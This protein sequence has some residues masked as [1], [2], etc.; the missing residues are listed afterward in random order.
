LY[1][2]WPL[3]SVVPVGVLTK[4]KRKQWSSLRSGSEFCA[5][6]QDRPPYHPAR[7]SCESAPMTEGAA[8]DEGEGEWG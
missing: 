2:G 7:S 4:S 6:A 1:A 5:A 3:A 8:G